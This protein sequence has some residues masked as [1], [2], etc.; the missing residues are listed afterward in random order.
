MKL[1]F[2][3]L[4][5]CSKIYC[6]DISN[7]KHIIIESGTKEIY[8]GHPTTLLMPD[9]KTMYCVWTIGHSGF[10]GPMA[11]SKDAG[12]TWKRIDSLLP[13]GFSKHRDCPSIYLIEDNIWVFSSRPN[14]SRIMYNGEWKEYPALGFRCTMSFSSIIK[15]K[16]YYYGYYHRRNIN[17]FDV[18]MSR[19]KDGFSWSKP[20]V[21][22]YM[23]KRQL[24]EPF[25]FYSPDSTE[26]CCIMRDDNHRGKSA[27][28]YSKNGKKWSDPVDTC[29][30]LTGDRHKGIYLPDG[31][32]LVAFRDR[33]K[34]S[35]TY[36]HFVCWVGRYED[37]KEKG[38]FRVKLLH[39]Y[40]GYDCGY[41]GVHILPDSTI[42]ATTY[43]KYNEF[44]QSIV[45][46]RFKINEL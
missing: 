15:R 36:G 43:I 27:V 25:V 23:F 46:T 9:N 2:T 22:A 14:M 42:V 7:Q 41:S 6:Q 40:D 32:L 24:S 18:M 30:G 17:T 26:L 37:I 5:I 39:S 20:K 35:S 11:V 4:F 12:L 28:M 13:I 3:V 10:C 19:T 38:D 34:G 16:N 33:A 44:L 8:Q 1:I 29:W 31:R 45:S 21:V